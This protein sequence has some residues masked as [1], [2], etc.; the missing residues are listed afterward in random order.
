M[1]K[2][3][4]QESM[5]LEEAVGKDP[6]DGSDLLRR[7]VVIGLQPGEAVD[8]GEVFPFLN[9]RDETVDVWEY[10]SQYGHRYAFRLADG[11]ER[12][13]AFKKPEHGIVIPGVPIPKSTAYLVIRNDAG[14]LTATL[15]GMDGRE[16]DAEYSAQRLNTS[17]E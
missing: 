14:V 7:P 12:P 4:F 10:S 2:L 9:N 6:R 13:P 1:E 8:L 17:K 16:W 5:N 15:R 11:T 3:T